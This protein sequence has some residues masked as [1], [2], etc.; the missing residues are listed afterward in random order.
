MSIIKSIQELKL[1]KTDARPEAVKFKLRNFVDLSTLPK[2]PKRFGHEDL[3]EKKSWGMLGNDKFGSC[4]FSGAAHETMM[5]TLECGKST[6]FD[7][8]SVLSDYSAVTGFDP[9]N[10]NTDN[11]TDMKNAAAYRRDTGIVDAAGIRHKVAAYL[12]IE[13]GNLTEHYIAMYLFGAVGIGIQFPN[14]AMEQFNKNKTWT[15]IKNS[16]IVGGHYIPLVAKRRS[17]QCVTW[18]QTQAMSIGF[19][20]KYNDESIVFLSEE[21]LVSRKSPEGFDY[22]GLVKSLNLL[23]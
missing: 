6:K 9:S 3:I 22:D 18:G 1:G 19:F 14:S 13:A 20:N 16:R 12:S 8:K 5:W 10:P 4:V 2:P 23:K 11:G 17:L 21:A 7:D 15:V